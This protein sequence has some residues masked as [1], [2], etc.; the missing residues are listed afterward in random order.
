MQS[1]QVYIALGQMA[2]QALWSMLKGKEKKPPFEHG[3]SI[4]LNE[5]QLLILSYHPSQQNT[6]TGKLTW[7][8][9]ERVFQMAQNHLK[10]ATH[11]TQR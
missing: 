5:K 8:M 3:L 10:Y 2:Y 11:L 7:P 9:F 4:K 6:F 1:V